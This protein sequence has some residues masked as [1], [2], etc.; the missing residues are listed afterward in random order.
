M[1]TREIIKIKNGW[2]VIS[3]AEN[4]ASYR[5]PSKAKAQQQVDAWEKAEAEAILYRAELRAAR[6]ESAKAY[7]ESRKLRIN[8]QL[9]FDF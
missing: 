2:T 7:C 5:Y 3:S 6:V 9:R 1:T 8:N 4:E